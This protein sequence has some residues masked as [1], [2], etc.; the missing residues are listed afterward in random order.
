VV[1]EGIGEA[2]KRWKPV[3]FAHL[4]GGK[5]QARVAD[6][7]NR[8][9]ASQSSARGSLCYFGDCATLERTEASEGGRRSTWG[10]T[11]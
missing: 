11:L 10:M 1:T 6:D 3:F 2:S 8:M 7:K 9:T 5:S 4:C